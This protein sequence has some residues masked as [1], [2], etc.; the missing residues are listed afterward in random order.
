M[1]TRQDV[2]QRAA[3]GLQRFAER[4]RSTHV[5]VG[6]D[7]F[8]DSIIAVVD[9][10]FSPTDYQPIG[11]IADFGRKILDAAGQSSNYELVIK[12]QKLGG[13]GPIM[14]NALVEATLAVTFIGCIGAPEIHPVF[15]DFAERCHAC[16]PVS[17]PGYTDAFEFDDGKLLF[18]KHSN[19]RTLGPRTIRDALGDERFIET[20]NR[21]ELLAMVNWTMLPHTS[22]IWR[23]MLDDILPKLARPDGNRLS[24]FIDLCD[25][26]KR[27]TESLVEAMGL[28][29]TM[30]TY[31]DVTLGLNL[32]ES[33]QVAA[34]LGVAVDGDPEAAIETTAAGIREKMGI[35]CV[36]IHPR[37]SAA[38]ARLEGDAVVT[39]HF[40]G[41]YVQQPKLSTG[42]G[43][44]CNA[45]FCLGCLAGLDLQACLAVGTALSGYYVRN[46]G[47]PT[48][49]QLALFAANLPEP[50]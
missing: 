13:N 3:E 1:S 40:P 25:P 28:L 47:S 42:A 22:E 33:T 38:A 14:A 4:A 26:E 8:V 2:C 23:Y 6:F 5:M 49:E 19:I 15:G 20:L 48:L 24:V 31:A 16:L 50:E 9:K 39:A 21:C 11:Q 45:G 30:Q 35:T 29:G 41:P 44:N 12:Q 18:G 43:D 36:M 32:K 27:T 34:A 46:A 37:K 10:R 7:G 17:D